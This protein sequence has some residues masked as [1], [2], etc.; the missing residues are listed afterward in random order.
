MQSRDKNSGIISSKN[1]PISVSY[2]HLDVY[3]RQST[4]R[5]IK[6]ANMT[7]TIRHAAVFCLFTL[8]LFVIEGILLFSLKF[9]RQKCIIFQRGI[10]LEKISDTHLRLSD[11]RARIGKNRRHIDGRGF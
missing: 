6:P 11:E 5:A 4:H 9:H 7:I 8:L 10:L 2:T 3:K 1:T